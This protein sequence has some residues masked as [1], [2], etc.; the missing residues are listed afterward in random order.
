MWSLPGELTS[1]PLTVGGVGSRRW[2]CESTDEDSWRVEAIQ[3][4]SR[5]VTAGGVGQGAGT[6]GGVGQ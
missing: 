1:H 4:G 3:C 5:D 6:A 2:R